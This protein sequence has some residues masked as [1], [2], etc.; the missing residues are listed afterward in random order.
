MGIN[1]AIIADWKPGFSSLYNGVEVQ[2]VADEIMTITDEFESAT[3]QQIVDKARDERT[4]LHKCFTWDDAEAAEKYRRD[5]A[6]HL[7]RCIVIKRE[8]PSEDKPVVRLFHKVESGQ[9][10]KPATV[11]IRK[12][13]EYEMLLSRARADIS[14]M[15]LSQGVTTC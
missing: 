3:P 10:Y 8:E 5:E 7:V 6:R 9:G 14:I 1:M 12:Q 13:D 15:E 2:K 4:E 11:I